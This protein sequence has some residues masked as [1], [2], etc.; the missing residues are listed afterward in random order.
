[1]KLS[2]KAALLS[3]LLYPGAGFFLFKR[4]WLGLLFALPATLAIIYIFSY[5]MDVA[6]VIADRIVNGQ[7]APTVPAIRAAIQAALAEENWHLT[8]AKIAFIVAWLGSI[9]FSWWLGVMAEKNNA[10]VSA[11]TSTPTQAD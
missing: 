6:S 10:I 1:M 7:I 3:G 5:T 8:L 2:M 4:Y 9:P 11:P